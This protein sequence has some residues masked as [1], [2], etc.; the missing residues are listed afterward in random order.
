MNAPQAPKPVSRRGAPKSS[1]RLA[2]EVALQGLYEW[3]LTGS[4][5][6]TI[7]AHMAEQEGFERCDRAH[8]DAL[9]CGCIEE[10][11][12]LDAVLARQVDRPT[13]ELSPV[14][15]AILLIGAY[16]LRHC[17][18]VPYKVAINEA[19]ELAKSFGGTDGHRYV[20]GVLDRTAAELRPHEVQAARP[21][22]RG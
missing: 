8:L 13:Q 15:H 12:A 16:E 1:R 4:D 14:E 10:A 7:L 3:L 22:A 2:R 20:N 18:D 9:L 21:P 17:L 11:A 19:V 6:G 5:S